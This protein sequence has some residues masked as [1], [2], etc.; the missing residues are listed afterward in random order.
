MDA[1]K[2]MNLRLPPILMDGLRARADQN[3][4]SLTR[5]AELAIER[6]LAPAF[7]TQPEASR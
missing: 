2:A 3:K 6:Y 7:P 1:R 4:R 5:E